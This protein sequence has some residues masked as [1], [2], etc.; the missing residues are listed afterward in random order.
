MERSDIGVLSPM[1]PAR[2]AHAAPTRVRPRRRGRTTAPAVQFPP[3]PNREVLAR[4]L[5][6]SSV[7][8]L[9]L[10]AP[11][12]VTL[13]PAAPDAVQQTDPTPSATG[14][15]DN[16]G[17]AKLAR[18]PASFPRQAATTVVIS[19]FRTRGPSSNGYAS[20]EFIEL[21]NLTGGPVDIGGWSLWRSPDCTEAEALF[22]TFSGGTMLA[23]GQHLLVGGLNY[24]GGV[25]ADVPVVDMGI[26]D[27]GG[28][29]LKDAAV[30]PNVVD[31]VGM[32]ET[33]Q[34]FEPNPLPALVG[35]S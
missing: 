12:L 6:L 4:G 11:V 9:F 24:S 20:D 21:F 18:P 5:L 31:M 7:A 25:A 13:T 1:H 35:Q 8:L 27:Q 15:P 30:V 17:V 14:T 10:A 29:A 22:Y 23:S 34:Y 28:I 26:D 32:C 3:C 16:P 2:M 19:E 33:T